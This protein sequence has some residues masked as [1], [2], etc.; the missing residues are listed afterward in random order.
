MHPFKQNLKDQDDHCK[1]N[2]WEER[3][4]EHFH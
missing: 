2:D 3:E 4:A 1:E